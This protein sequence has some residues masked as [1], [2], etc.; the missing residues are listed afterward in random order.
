M[1]I[2]V[3]FQVSRKKEIGY[4]IYASMPIS[5]Q[6]THHTALS[7]NS[8]EHCDGESQL[9]YSQ[10]SADDTSQSF[11]Q[12]TTAIGSCNNRVVRNLNITTP[13][14]YVKNL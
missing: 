5:P 4:F 6:V 1:Q 11:N 10:L 14:E 8:E 12:K 2:T 9:M 13:S 3:W 7:I